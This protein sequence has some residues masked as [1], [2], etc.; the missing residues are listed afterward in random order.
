MSTLLKKYS[1]VE[2]VSD[3]GNDEEEY[4]VEVVPT[5]WISENREFCYYPPH[6]MRGKCT[7]LVMSL[8]DYDSSEW[9][10]LRI[11]YHH[12]YSTF[13]VALKARNKAVKEDTIVATDVDTDYS[14]PRNKKPPK[15]LITSSGSDSDEERRKNK[16]PVGS[17]IIP[18]PSSTLPS[19]LK[20]L[21]DSAKTKNLAKSKQKSSAISKF[22]SASSK[23][24]TTPVR[25]LLQEES[26]Q[27]ETTNDENLPEMLDEDNC[28]LSKLKSS[29]SKNDGSSLR[30]KKFSNNFELPEVAE[31]TS[32]CEQSQDSHDVST[33]KSDHNNEFRM[34]KKRDFLDRSP[35]SKNSSD[36]SRPTTGCR[37]CISTCSGSTGSKPQDQVMLHYMQ[38]LSAK[39]DWQNIGIAQILNELFPNEDGFDRP[40]GFPSL[41]LE[42]E[43]SFASFDGHLDDKILYGHMLKYLLWKGKGETTSFFTYS[44]LSTLLRN[45]LA[46]LI[47]WKGSGGIKLSF[48]KSKVKNLVE[49]YLPCYDFY[50][51]K[52]VFG[53]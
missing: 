5:K 37:S 40:E 2:F 35:P 48:E 17:H 33:L 52:R 46:R 28:S 34:N 14:K 42:T 32:I 22:F 19:N 25:Q 9:K 26:T 49:G 3:P 11:I 30:S 50:E 13:N 20:K 12:S 51:G 27:A 18:E 23:K 21:L 4:L 47:S 15:R 29:V 31:E 43:E 36:D 41:P 7:K 53:R 45:N 39:I 16:K 6:S 8:A 38:E 24:D 1:V 44:I 10:L